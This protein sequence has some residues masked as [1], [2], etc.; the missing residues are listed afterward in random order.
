MDDDIIQYHSQ[1]AMAELDMALGASCPDAARA[2][3]R[4]SSLHLEKSQKL[5]GSSRPS[6]AFPQV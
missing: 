4:L 3:F 5:G 6:P 2:H 1:R